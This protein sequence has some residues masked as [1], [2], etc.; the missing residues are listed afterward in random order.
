M[1]SNLAF[2][3]KWCNIRSRNP[4]TAEEQHN[5]A[6]VGSCS[7]EDFTVIPAA[8]TKKGK[9]QVRHEARWSVYYRKCANMSLLTESFRT[10]TRES[11][12]CGLTLL[13]FLNH[14]W[15]AT[16]RDSTS[17]LNRPQSDW[18][19]L[20][21]PCLLHG[22]LFFKKSAFIRPRLEIIPLSNNMSRCVVRCS[23][24]I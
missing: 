21:I 9:G 10:R 23:L 2:G 14:V 4:K 24:L 20:F 19:Q 12:L 16:R 11:T 22:S 17:S 13:K 6:N 18:L 1:K 8:M 15:N 7:R 3:P 5:N